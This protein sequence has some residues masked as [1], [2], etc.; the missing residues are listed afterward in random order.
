MFIVYILKS[1]KSGRFYIGYTA[2]ISA[3]L[4]A[5]NSGR[6]R[7]TKAGAPWQPVYQEY[8]PTKELAFKREQQIKRYKGGEAFK[9]LLS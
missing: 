8:F 3:R 1:S 4:K 7:S 6:N 5:H 9:K 2:D